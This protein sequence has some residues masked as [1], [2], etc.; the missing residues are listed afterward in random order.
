MSALECCSSACSR[1]GCAMLSPLLCYNI[2]FMGFFPLQLILKHH[3][4]PKDQ[5]PGSH[6]FCAFPSK[7]ILIL[8]WA[9]VICLIASLFSAE[10]LC[11]A[12]KRQ[13]LSCGWHGKG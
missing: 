4:C 8:L 3:Q 1:L 13:T 9:H 10:L 12:R 6:Q 5:K 11:F 7:A 2:S